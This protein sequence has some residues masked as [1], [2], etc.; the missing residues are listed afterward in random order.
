MRVRF[1]GTSR[2][3]WGLMH[4]GSAFSPTD[5][6][7]APLRSEECPRNK[8]LLLLRM[9]YTP[10]HGPRHVHLS[11][12]SAQY[13]DYLVYYCDSEEGEDP[14]VHHSVWTWLVSA[15]EVVGGDDP[16][17]EDGTAGRAGRVGQGGGGRGG[18]GQGGQGSRE[19]R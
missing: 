15:M 18:G 17:A 8:S 1:H 6:S 10:T 4:A 16:A 11:R 9:Q 12:W 19:K 5:Q 13:S 3:V 2:A 14:E 7:V